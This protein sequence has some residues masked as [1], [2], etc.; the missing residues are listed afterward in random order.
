MYVAKTLRITADAEA[1]NEYE[2]CEE[3]A[4]FA[5][6][7]GAGVEGAAGPD[8]PDACVYMYVCMYVCMC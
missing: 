1:S 7:G 2:N 5:G 4:A 3:A 8:R 6:G